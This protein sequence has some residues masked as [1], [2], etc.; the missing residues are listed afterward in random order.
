M[1]VG[2]IKAEVDGVKSEKCNS[3]EIE[4]LSLLDDASSKIALRCAVHVG[5]TN[6]LYWIDLA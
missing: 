3:Y 5:V 1:N 4:I 6:N 2:V